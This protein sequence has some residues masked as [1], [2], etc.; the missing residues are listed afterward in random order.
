MQRNKVLAQ[1]PARERGDVEPAVLLARAAEKR[2]GGTLRFDSRQLSMAIACFSDFKQRAARD[3]KNVESGNPVPPMA[4]YD[5][6][7]DSWKVTHEAVVEARAHLQ[8]FAAEDA[9]FVNAVRLFKN[10]MFTND[11]DAG[12]VGPDFVATRRSPVGPESVKAETAV[13]KPKREVGAGCWEA[14]RM[15]VHWPGRPPGVMV[16]A[17]GIYNTVT[18]EFEPQEYVGEAMDIFMDKHPHENRDELEGFY[19]REAEDSARRR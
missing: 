3:L 14:R 10:Y 13:V 8:A 6:F 12:E 16:E 15:D 18:R 1:K 2:Q 19:W 4:I 9:D 7:L 11:P 17:I 5:R